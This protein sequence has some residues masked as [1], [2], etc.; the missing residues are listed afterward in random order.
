[1]FYEAISINCILIDTMIQNFKVI[2]KDKN[3]FELILN[4]YI[5][6]YSLFIFLCILNDPVFFR[7]ILG[8]P[9]S[10]LLM[11]LNH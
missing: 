6:I 4:Y 5:S 10:Y 7:V 9:Y 11:Y 8:L 1:M 3:V 2:L